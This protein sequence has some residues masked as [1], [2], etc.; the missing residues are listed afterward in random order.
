[1]GL[2]RARGVKR[3]GVARHRRMTSESCRPQNVV[4]MEPFRGFK[5]ESPHPREM[6]IGMGYRDLRHIAVGPFFTSSHM[7]FLWIVS[8]PLTEHQFGVPYNDHIYCAGAQKYLTEHQF[9]YNPHD[10]GRISMYL[11]VPRIGSIYE[12][13]PSLLETNV[14]SIQPMV[15]V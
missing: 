3:V 7:F 15:K 10:I 8:F 11:R 6:G 12:T 2:R 9:G 13:H 5:G 4:H 14:C 1:M